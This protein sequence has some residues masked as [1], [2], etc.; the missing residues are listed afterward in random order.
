VDKTGRR[1]PYLDEI[2]FQFAGS[3]EA[4]VLRFSAG[5]ADL[6]N[7]LSARDFAFLSKERESRAYRL[8]DLGAGLEYSFIFFNLTPGASPKIAWF[9]HKEFR[10]ALSLAIDRE[11]L[12]RLVYDGRAVPL[13]SH[14]PPGNRLWVNSH[15]QHGERSPEKARALLRDSGFH[16]NGHGEL[17]DTSGKPVEF[18]IVTSASNPERVQMATIIQDDLK[19][20]GVRVQVVP[21]EFRVL[22][23][24]VLNKREFEACLLS[25]GNGDADPNAEMNIW[26]ST[27]ATHLWN[28]SQ[29]EPATEW[30]REIDGL[31]REQLVTMNYPRRK[32]LYDRVQEIVAENVPMIFLTSPNVLVAA[33]GNLGNFRP[34]VLDHHTLWNAD[35]LF[36]TDRVADRVK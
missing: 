10:R 20:I 9:G 13:W 26:M 6:L 36:L 24:K 21:L 3:E 30:E 34:A 15:L 35:R 14:V 16:W 23:D 18:S 5:Q 25:L 32:K 11:A 19:Q 4:Q 12:V 7:R 29:K 28:P 2:A 33:R 27:G 31:M 8:E 17:E 22:L 1:L